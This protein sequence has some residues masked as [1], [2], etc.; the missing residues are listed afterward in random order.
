MS[1]LPVKTYHVLLGRFAPVHRGHQKTLDLLLERYGHSNVI[2]LIGSSN[3]YNFRTPYTYKDRKAMLQTLY[4]KLTILPLPDTNPSLVHFD[5]LKNERWLD[6]ISQI[7]SDMSA[8]FIFCGGSTE[9][10]AVLS[11]RFQSE[12]FV[13]REGLGRGY[14]ATQVR[15][16]LKDHDLTTLK[17]LLSPKVIPLA[18]GGYDHFLKTVA[19]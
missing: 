9:D 4:P 3:S 6:Q 7:E 14:S 11:E 15:Q 19:C 8:K 18:I 13:N 5:G 2:A 12:I 10:L 1:P 16:A 17:K